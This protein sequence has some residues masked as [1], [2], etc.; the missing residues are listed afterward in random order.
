MMIRTPIFSSGQNKSLYAAISSQVGN[1]F[2]QECSS[3]QILWNLEVVCVH[4]CLYVCNSVRMCVPWRTSAP[5]QPYP[6][7]FTAAGKRLIS[8]V[9]KRYFSSCLALLL[10]FH[11]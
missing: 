1:S 8:V 9:I 5:N 3:Y 2:N 11:P 7:Q 6:V 4:V 10:N